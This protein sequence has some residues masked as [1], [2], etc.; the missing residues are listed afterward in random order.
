MAKYTGLTVT[1]K[2]QNVTVFFY[3]IPWYISLSIVKT[4]AL[5][6]V[7]LDYCN[8]LL[9]STANKDIAKRQHVQTILAMIVTRSPRVS[10]S[11]TL[12]KSLDWRCGK[13]HRFVQ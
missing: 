12:L 11:V 4:S 2:F 3:R 6:N 13:Q 10:C 5:V 8:S 7:R 1:F 9:Y